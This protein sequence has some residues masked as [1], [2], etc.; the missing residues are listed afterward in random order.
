MCLMWSFISQK[1]LILCYNDLILL[2]KDLLVYYN[3][4][5]LCVLALLMCYN[6]FQELVKE[7]ASQ[8]DH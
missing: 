6:D 3:D 1:D 8:T 4:L 5:I 7:V 2:G